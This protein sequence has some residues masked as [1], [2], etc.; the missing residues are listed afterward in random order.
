MY[1]NS[2]LGQCLVANG[3]GQRLLT[4]AGMSSDAQLESA[5]VMLDAPLPS[6]WG[7]EFRDFAPNKLIGD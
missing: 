4:E 3:S 5:S 7:A 1:A 2:I 6:L